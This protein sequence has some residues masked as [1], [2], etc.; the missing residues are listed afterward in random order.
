[1]NEL[2]SGVKFQA[3]PEGALLGVIPRWIGCQ[4]FV[5]NAKREE[6]RYACALRRMALKDAG[7]S[8][9][10]EQDQD[11]L[12]SVGSVDIDRLYAQFKD[13]EQTHWLYEVPS[14]VLRE[15]TYRW[16]NAMQR[17]LKGLGS[18][19]ARRTRANF[20][21]VL[22]FDDLFCLLDGNRIELGTVANPIGI[23]KFKPHRSYGT[24]KQISIRIEAGKW[25]VSFSYD[26]SSDRYKKDGSLDKDH[27][28]AKAKAENGSQDSTEDAAKHIIRSQ[29]ELAYE[30]KLLSSDDLNSAVVGIDRNTKDNFLALSTG[31]PMKMDA[32]NLERIARKQQ[33]AKRHQRQLAR[34]KKGSANRRKIIKK[35][36]R[37]RGYEARCRQ[38]F[39]HK[40]S[41]KLV[42]S[43]AKM[44]V[45]EDLKIKNMTKAPA[46]KQDEQGRYLPNGAAAKAGLNKAI[47][48]S[49][50]GRIT[51]FTAYKAERA[52]VLM[53]KVPPHHTSQECSACRHTHPGN[54]VKG[55]F[56]CQRCGHTEHAD[57]NAAK[58]IARRGIEMLNTDQLVFK[59]EPKK[60]VAVKRKPKNKDK[61]QTTGMEYPEVSVETKPANEGDPFRSL[62][63]LSIKAKARSRKSIP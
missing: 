47:L 51:Q 46:P 41:R 52:N 29:E 43:G 20:N 57:F 25:F 16:F 56:L 2:Q 28:K 19:P 62:D 34:A 7:Y 55:V 26:H 11:L 49:C 24:P 6:W 54:R 22:L 5:Y 42:D 33:G 23:L 59:T 32:V 58:N 63:D 13:K 3:V 15:G 30:L 40:T 35:L 38:D 1:M 50:W 8:G 48:S 39:S 18:S 36:A 60:R 9:D 10:A 44:L 17:M 21:T 61:S 14:Q 53:V 37:K 27:Q 12:E 45:F 4:R 31:Q